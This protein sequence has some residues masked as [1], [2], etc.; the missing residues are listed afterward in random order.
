VAERSRPLLQANTRYQRALKRLL[1]KSDLKRASALADQLRREFQQTRVDVRG[2]A[3]RWEPSRKQVQTRLRRLLAR[4]VPRH[5]EVRTLQRNHLREMQN[6]AGRWH[7]GIPVAG[8]ALPDH[9]P[10]A[11]IFTPPFSLADV[12]VDHGGD[13][14]LA[15]THRSFV[16][17]EIGHLILDADFDDDEHTSFSDGLWG[18]LYVN[19]ADLVASCGVSY[20]MPRAGRVRVTADLKNF[21]NHATL[22]LK[23]NW[24]FSAGTLRCS[25]FLF[26]SVLRPSSEAAQYELL[27]EKKLTSDGDNTSGVMP[28]IDQTEPLFLDVTTDETFNQGE[29]VWVMVGSIVSVFS[30]LDDM[31][32]HVRGLLWWQ[33]ERIGV[34]VVD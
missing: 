10:D 32:S 14:Q 8:I 31:H 6:I 4:A 2:S 9:P 25:Y 23:D 12:H 20:T 34:T 3:E 17:P 27:F 24:G 28:D 29:L 15:V 26:G 13:Q 1:S 22:S 21:Y 33:V 30:R 11:T 19:V 7:A 18:L 5:R 16:V